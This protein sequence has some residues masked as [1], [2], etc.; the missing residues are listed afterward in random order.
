MS[1]EGALATR[2]DSVVVSEALRTSESRVRT[3]TSALLRVLMASSSSL[4]SNVPPEAPAR[5]LTRT[6]R[7][8]SPS[9]MAFRRRTGSRAG[10]GQGQQVDAPA[11]E[12]LGSSPCEGIVTLACTGLSRCERHTHLSDSPSPA[13]LGWVALPVS[14]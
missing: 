7:R 11:D 1:V 13:N 6:R 3:A 2:G 4:S 8:E 12:T 9:A 10:E 5:V 14:G